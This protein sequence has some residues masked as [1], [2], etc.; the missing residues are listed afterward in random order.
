MA[1]EAK[2]PANDA[3]VQKACTVYASA[4]VHMSIPKAVALL[5]MGHHAVRSYRN[6][7][8]VQDASWR[9]WSARSRRTWRRERL[10]WPSWRRRG[11]VNTGSIDPLEE[12]AAIAKRHGLWMHVDGAYGALAAIAAPEKFRGLALADSLSLD[13]AQMAIS[14]AGLWLP[15]VSRSERRREIV[16]DTAAITRSHCSPI[17]WRA[18]RSSKRSME[19]SRRFRALKLWLSFRYHGMSAFREAIRGDLQ[20][21]NDLAG[22]IA[23]RKELEILAPVPLSAVC[24]LATGARSRLR[25]MN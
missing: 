3:G 12:I 22:M 18:S 13:P 25:T 2:A 5:G 6:R 7:R 9:N 15:A 20:L 4:E 10:R 17:R 21:A 11:T 16:F 24:V 1:R 23:V 8:P 19:L 14:A